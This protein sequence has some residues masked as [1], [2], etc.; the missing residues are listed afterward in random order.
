MA[1]CY[2][3][4]PNFDTRKSFYKKARVE[5]EGEKKSLYSYSTKV[6]EID[7]S[8]EN[9][10]RVNILGFYS[11]TTLR[12]IKDFLYQEGFKVGSQ[13][14]LREEYTSSGRK[15]KKEKEAKKIEKELVKA[16]KEKERKERE[17]KRAIRRVEILE[18]KKSKLRR[19]IEKELGDVLSVQE[20]ETLVIQELA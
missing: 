14:F 12:H 1:E 15:E 20:I 5:K 6:C 17:E 8:K 18:N 13:Q 9:S 7:Y 4:E 10:E 3:L 2:F 19:K 11:N 16:Q